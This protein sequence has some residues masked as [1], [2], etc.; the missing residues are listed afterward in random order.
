MVEFACPA[1]WVGTIEHIRIYQDSGEKRTG[2]KSVSEAA[3]LLE[4]NLPAK[5]HL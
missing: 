2:G 4:A 3:A 1:E 5:D